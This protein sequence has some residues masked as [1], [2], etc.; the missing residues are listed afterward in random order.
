MRAA[1]TTRYGPPEVVRIEDVPTPTPAERDLLVRVHVT[2]VNRTDWGFRAGKPFFIRFFSGLP[3]PK[4]TILGNDFAGVVEAV[5]SGV[6]SFKVGD[7]VFGFSG[8][9]FG[10]H[11]E[12][13]RIP[14]D[15]LVES[16]PATATYE[17]AGPGTEGAHYALTIIAAARIQRDQRVLVNGA[18][19]AIGSAA[20]QILRHLGASITATCRAEHMDLVRGLGAER[21]IDY[22]SEDFTRDG[23]RFDVVM[24][25][26]G[27]SSFGRCRRLL[28]PRGIYAST[29]L[30]PLSMNPLL[31]LVT[32]LSG[33]KRAMLP[34]P[35]G[36][37]QTVA[38]LRTLIESGEFTPVIDRRYPLEQIVD[39][40]RYMETGQKV[41]SVVITVGSSG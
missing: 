28:K 1:V 25:A 3:K 5:G 23:E 17:Q 31:S 8:T 24:D 20:V 22:T 2:T 14:E 19:G 15:G 26:V 33:G 11:A 13:L 10:A 30:G 4:L 32:R 12:H 9:R 27:K 18:T 21:V 36:N 38:Q 39:A 35:R 40:Y 16:V 41:G 37:L 29:D 34:V 6:C 7:R